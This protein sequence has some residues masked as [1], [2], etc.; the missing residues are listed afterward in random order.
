MT[1]PFIAIY[2]IL[3]SMT[4]R[5]DNPGHARYLTFGCFRRKHLFARP[6]LAK[7]FL[8]HLD[9]WRHEHAITLLAYV[10]M[11][12]H[13]HLLLH[14]EQPNLGKLLGRLKSRFGREA[15]E[16]LRHG[17]PASWN[18]LRAIDHGKEMRRFWQAGG[19]YDRNVFTNQSIMKA[20]EYMHNNPVRAGL[21]RLPE[22]Y[23]WSSAKHWLLGLDEPLRIDRPEWL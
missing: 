23:A 8:Q 11:A 1:S 5:F 15:L 16:Q 2:N 6:G 9:R 19:G 14:T 21:V 4:T 18:E 7:L 17:S 12:N 20:I 10:I 13:V 3:Y 22:E